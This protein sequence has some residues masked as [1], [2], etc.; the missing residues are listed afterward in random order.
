MKD[1]QLQLLTDKVEEMD[2]SVPSS[3]QEQIRAFKNSL[4]A[5]VDL[6]AGCQQGSAVDVRTLGSRLA[7]L[8]GANKPKQAAPVASEKFPE[9]Q[10][11]IYGADLKL[12][13]KRPDAKADLIGVEISFGVSCGEDTMLLLYEWRDKKWWQVLRWQSGGYNAV[14]GA[15]GD[16][17]EYVVIPHGG[18]GKWVVA[19][20]HGMPWCTSRYSGFDLD[21]VETAH[22][23]APQNLLFHKHAGYDRGDDRGP[24]LKGR[25]DGFELRLRDFGID[26][27]VYTRTEIYRYQLAV[28]DVKRMQPVAMNGRDFVDEW[29]RSDWNEAAAWTVTENLENLKSEHAVIEKLRDPKTAGTWPTFSFRSVRGCSG[30]P[31]RFQ[32][33]LSL[34][35]GAPIYFGIREGVDSFT[36]LSALSQPDP[37]CK[38]A[39]LMRER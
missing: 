23:S 28:R 8:L 9:L 36:M 33:E 39:D 34:D 2:T 12:V 17:F 38:G 16:F 25:S 3:T 21:A 7:G 15:Y 32:V 1:L 6:Y 13:A 22:D 24:V 5:A 29:I 20:A 18:L 10:Q 37:L 30:D 35:P 14:N 26:F 31:K 4:A 11:Q 27:D 19:V